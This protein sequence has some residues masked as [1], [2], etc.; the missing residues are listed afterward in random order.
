MVPGEAALKVGIIDVGLGN[1]GS[2]KGA[3]ESLGWDPLLITD[4]P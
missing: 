2:L 4:C 1:T 3:L